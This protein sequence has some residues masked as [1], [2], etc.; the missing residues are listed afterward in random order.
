MWHSSPS[1]KVLW[2][3]SLLN[4]NNFVRFCAN[5]IWITI[6]QSRLWLTLQRKSIVQQK[7]LKNKS[8]LCSHC[9]RREII[10]GLPHCVTT[11]IKVLITLLGLPIWNRFYNTTH[12]PPLTYLRHLKTVNNI[13]VIPMTYKLLTFN[14]HNTQHVSINLFPL[15]NLL[16]WKEFENLC[17]EVH[18]H[19][20]ITTLQAIG[21]SPCCVITV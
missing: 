4:W 7:L 2:V 3:C 15:N 11:Y 21:N 14:T 8:S 18:R 19:P 9:Q 16:H 5:I 17:V 6:I 1:L 12:S 20:G 10:Y 13:L